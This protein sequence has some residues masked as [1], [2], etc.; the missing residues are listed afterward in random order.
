ML[1]YNKEEKNENLKNPNKNWFYIWILYTIIIMSSV[2]ELHIISGSMFSG[3]T[4]ELLNL[5]T[6]FSGDDTV[7]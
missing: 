6:L 3:K 1:L 7:L 2:G 5:I 4:T